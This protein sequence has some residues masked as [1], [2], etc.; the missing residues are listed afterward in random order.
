MHNSSDKEL[1]A[2][3]AKPTPTATAPRSVT[4]RSSTIVAG[5]RQKPALRSSAVASPSGRGD[6]VSAGGRDSASGKVRNSV[7]T[8]ADPRASDEP[9]DQTRS[10]SGGVVAPVAIH[11]EIDDGVREALGLPRQLSHA[12]AIAK[13]K[14]QIEARLSPELQSN[15]PDFISV[16]SPNRVPQDEPQDELDT[17]DE[18]PSPAPGTNVQGAN[19][20]KKAGAAPKKPGPSGGCGCV[21]Q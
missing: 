21:I 1:D 3:P 7:V 18:A 5:M 2:A 9:S 4:G 20:T 6:S 13:L 15:Q 8:F 12:D 17:A 14:F 19:N 16:L 10:G 11:A